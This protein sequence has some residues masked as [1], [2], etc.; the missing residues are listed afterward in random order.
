MTVEANAV[1]SH[2]SF[3]KY[4]LLLL[5]PTHQSDSHRCSAELKD[6]QDNQENAGVTATSPTGTATTAT[7][8][9]KVESAETVAAEA[10]K[11]APKVPTETLKSTDGDFKNWFTDSPSRFCFD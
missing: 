1:M 2:S 6:S 7:E 3:Q 11:G 8:K 5:Y 4:P 10:L 9:S